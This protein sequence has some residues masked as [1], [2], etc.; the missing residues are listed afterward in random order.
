MKDIIKTVFRH[1]K[2]SGGTRY[3]C[4]IGHKN[5]ETG[6]FDAIYIPLQFRQGVDVPDRSKIAITEMSL[7]Y[8][9]KKDGT[10]QLVIK[11]WDFGYVQPQQPAYQSQGYQQQYGYQSQGYQ[12]PQGDRVNYGNG[13]SATAQN[14]YQQPRQQPQP[15]PRQPQQQTLADFEAIDEQ[16]PF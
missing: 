11:V 15:Q 9:T 7:D 3:T 10:Q 5:R 13:F 16:V 1:D 6:Q 2:G 14:T 12:P 8:Y 4:A